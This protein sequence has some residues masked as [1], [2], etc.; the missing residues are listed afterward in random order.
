V[1]TGGLVSIVRLSERYDGRKR[2]GAKN[3]QLE[4]FNQE[5]LPA[6]T[7]VEL[8]LIRP[9]HKLVAIRSPQNLFMLQKALA[10]TDPET[11]DVVV[12]TAKLMPRE[13]GT[14][15]DP[16]LDPYGQQ[17]MT[18]VVNLAER[19]GKQVRPLIVPTNNPLHALLNTAQDLQAHEL[20]MGGSNKY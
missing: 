18:A 1:L 17:L 16:D 15:Y 20:I 8:E 19:A 14:E 2:E 11:T 5:T 10:E 9:Y 3:E 7:P 4:E 12:M 6:A 13:G